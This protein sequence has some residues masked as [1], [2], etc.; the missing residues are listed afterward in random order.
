MVRGRGQIGQR[1]R[2]QGYQTEPE[3]ELTGALANFLQEF[4][5]L[6]CSIPSQSTDCSG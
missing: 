4:R 5:M 2:R 6:S 1:G 3:R